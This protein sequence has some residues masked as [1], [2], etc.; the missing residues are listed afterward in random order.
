M[1]IKSNKPATLSLTHPSREDVIGW[2]KT[3]PRQDRPVNPNPPVPPEECQALSD[4]FDW[5]HSL[6]GDEVDPVPAM[7]FF[8]MV[9]EEDYPEHAAELKAHVESLF[10]L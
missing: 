8:C 9:L 3:Q 7:E 2:F 10:D 6:V 1:T 5:L 4:A